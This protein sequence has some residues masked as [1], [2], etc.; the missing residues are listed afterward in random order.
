MPEIRA[1]RLE[2]SVD[3]A[4]SQRRTK[5]MN[6]RA[7]LLAGAA[8]PLSLALDPRA[9]AARLAA[10]PVALVTADLESHVVVL[11]LAS[12]ETVR[13]IVTGPGPRS[14]ESV[15]GRV[16]VVAHTQHGVVSLIAGTRPAVHKE[17][18]TFAAP[19]YTAAHP[20]GAIAYVT[21]SS[22]EEVVALDN[23]RGRVL[24]RTH[25]PGPA[26]HVSISPDGR[27]VWTS[28]GSKAARIAVLDVSDRRRPRLVRTFAPPFLA[29]DVVFAPDGSGIWVTSGS[30]RR[31]ALYRPDS[32]RPQRLI[33]ADAAPQHVT[34][35]GGHAFVASGDDGTVRRH[36]LDGELVG[37]ASVP[38][39]S[40]NV[41]FGS[42]RVVSPSL[43]RG[44]L[45]ILDTRGRVRA[46]RHVARAAHDACIV[47]GL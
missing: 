25:V 32:R 8:V 42:G 43:E 26:R 4:R 33:A 37:Q 47:I 46:V 11:D 31:L 17:I 45:S 18:E 23:E 40:Y 44:T 16:A 20:A 28:L 6:R 10:T 38:V 12:G 7:F 19:R 29:H 5:A 22:N 3:L 41:T 30:E 14:I 15:L 1:R 21:D 13:Q 35:A 27:T 39:G 2:R 34:F 9:F 36:R 24:W